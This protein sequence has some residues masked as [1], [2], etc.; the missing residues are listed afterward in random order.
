MTPSWALL[1]LSC[2]IYSTGTALLSCFVPTHA[3]RQGSRGGLRMVGPKRPG[4]SAAQPAKK[5]G[6]AGLGQGRQEAQ[7]GQ[8]ER[9]RPPHDTPKRIQQSLGDL[10]GERFKKAKPADAK[11][12]AAGTDGDGGAG[13]RC[14]CRAKAGMELWCGLD[15]NQNGVD[16]NQNGVVLNTTNT[17]PLDLQSKFGKIPV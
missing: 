16:R 4:D 17:I 7:R 9:S 5:K 2:F 3:R 14:R 13:C 12:P 10:L 15:R 6:G 1:F 8:R 11:E